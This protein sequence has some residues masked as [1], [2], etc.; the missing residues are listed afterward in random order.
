MSTPRARLRL[1]QGVTSPRNTEGSVPSYGG[2][3]GKHVRR[4]YTMNISDT[5]ENRI[6]P[7]GYGTN[8]YQPQVVHAEIS[9]AMLYAVYLLG[10]GEIDS[11]VK[12]EVS[13]T[14]AYPTVVAWCAT[15]IKTG[16]LAQT[17][18]TEVLHA[19]WASSY[20][21]RA[22]LYLCLNLTSGK[23]SGGQ[24]EVEVTVKGLKVYDPRTTTTAWSE[25]PILIAR[26]LM[27][28]AE[29]G[30]GISSSLLDSTSWN[31][32]ADRC[33]ETVDAAAR[34]RAS[35]VLT[36]RR[37][38]IDVVR[39]MLKVTCGGFLYWADGK[40]YARLDEQNV[41]GCRPATTS[42]VGTTDRA[43]AF[44]APGPRIKAVCKLNLAGGF[45]NPTLRLRSTLAGSDLATAT[46]TGLSSGSNQFVTFD[47]SAYRL[48][49]GSTYYLVLNATTGVT[50]HQCTPSA[51]SGGASWNN[52]PGWTEESTKDFWFQVHF[53][54]HEIRD[55][56][57]AVAP[58][59]PMLASG[60][61]S[62]LSFSRSREEAPNVVE[63][64]FYDQTDWIVKPVRYEALEVQN[65]TKQPRT[66]SLHALAVPSSAC[67]YRL[68]RQWYKLAQRTNRVG[69]LVPQHGVIIAPEDV[70][71]LTSGIGPL[72]A[73]WYRVR[74]V[75]RRLGCFDLELVEYNW[76]DYS[77]ED[78]IT[79]DAVS[80]PVTVSTTQFVNFVDDFRSGDVVSGYLG[81]LGWTF[82]GSFTPSYVAEAEHPGIIVVA[83][84]NSVDSG[85]M[86]LNGVSQ[87]FAER[88][89]WATGWIFRVPDLP[90]ADQYCY[91]N[92]VFEVR[93]TKKSGV[94]TLYIDGV[95]TGLTCL[96][97]DWLTVQDSCD[98]GTTAYCNVMKAGAVWYQ[99]S[100]AVSS[101][102]INKY[103]KAFAAQFT[104][105]VAR[106]RVDKASVSMGTTR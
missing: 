23:F 64:S 79:L 73:V 90:V 82:A 68:A 58:E 67:A 44:V 29:Y 39:D 19:N 89:V 22:L 100:K 97:T 42:P 47:L 33:D 28:N 101:T 35:F 45:N 10:E 95:T 60:G 57:A 104:G 16:T 76:D 56:L 99:T 1:N 69:C 43:Q 27:V 9:G 65:G 105:G 92:D 12:V 20:P 59:I 88:S 31:A 40:W 86:S 91:V 94:W 72:T 51:Y 30:A 38:V 66:L 55:A 26:D 6:C 46:A 93:I 17:E 18:I 87:M 98:G 53:A 80:L 102:T 62:S 71:A 106:I 14:E 61:K 34:W 11:V 5:A 54:D 2:S 37:P 81:E 77:T 4:D 75:E 3:R 36:D 32:A 85:T 52:V 21:G 50:W 41:I 78:T 63:V 25:N 96:S 103:L 13:G 74:S 70:V 84:V 48:T 8:R 7:I 49:N 83:S 15:V 24:P